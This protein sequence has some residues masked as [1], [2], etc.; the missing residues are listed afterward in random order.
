MALINEV[1]MQNILLTIHLVVALLLIGAVLMQ[2]SEGGAL[3]IGGGSG[4]LFSSRGVGSAITRA[5]AIF[6]AIFFAT[7]IALTLLATR[8]GG[9]IFDGVSTTPAAVEGKASD[10]AKATGDVQLPNL[11]PSEPE[12]PKVPT[13]Q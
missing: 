10:G 3:G 6:A 13:N 9:S 12:T 1:I 7:S 8:K 2:R 5:T 4:N 11:K